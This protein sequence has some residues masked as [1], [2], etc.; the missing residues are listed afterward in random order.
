MAKPRGGGPRMNHTQTHHS[1]SNQAHWQALAVLFQALSAN[2]LQSMLLGI[3]LA[4]ATVLM[5]ALL[6]GISGWFITSTAIAGLAATSAIA[7]DVFTPSASIRLLALGR[8]ASRYGERV[9][10]HSAALNALVD[11]RERV[12]RAF[13][14]APQDAPNSQ[15]RLQPARMLL[16]LTRDLNAAESLYLRLI[17]PCCTAFVSTLLISIWLAF[18]HLWLGIAVFAW[19]MVSGISITWWLVRNTTA[20]ALTQSRQAEHMRQQALD[21]AGGQA[22]LVMAGQLDA[23]Q[24]RLN[25]K[26]A[27]V[28]QLDTQL[29]RTDAMAA[30]AWQGLHSLTM[31]AAVLVAA[32]LVLQGMMGVANAAFFILMAMAGMEPFASLRRGAMEW[33]HTFL[34]AKRLH[35]PLTQQAN[36]ALAHLPEPAPGLAAQLRNVHVASQRGAARVHDCSLDIARGEI[37]AIVGPS[38]SGKSS[39]LALISG[40]LAA[41]EGQVRAL[42]C[43]ALPQQTALFND[44]VRANVNLQQRDVSD[45]AIWSALEAAGLRDVI[46]ARAQGLDETLGEAGLGLSKGQGRR[47][48][49][50]RLFLTES[51]FWLLDEPTDGLD[52]DT[53]GDVLERLAYTL[54]GKTAVIA[55]H[56]QREAALASRLLVVEAGR[57]TQQ[58]VRGTPQFNAILARLRD[59]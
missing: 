5:G 45:D 24:Q 57:V 43:V 36:Y 11:V 28:A 27:Q 59:G 9:T 46:A 38:G 39:L 12:F 42:S 31:A 20:A 58:V 16:R 34:A 26:Q 29:Q 30:A 48:A 3:G 25:T 35:K 53:A 56:M 21:I 40:E 1:N 22:E 50:A 2:R 55:T 47:L 33:A 37:V 6:L 51:H 14:A 13:A 10:T 23:W 49:L 15:W 19:F 4:C 41:T 8:T 52:A 7:F 54:Q 44:S 32:W 17:V 18:H